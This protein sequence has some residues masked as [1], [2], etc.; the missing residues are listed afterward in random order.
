MRFLTPVPLLFTL[1]CPTPAEPPPAPE[2]PRA[3]LELYMHPDGKT[4]CV[5]SAD[6]EWQAVPSCCPDGFSLAG[7]SAPAVSLYLTEEEREIR[8]IYRHVVCLEDRR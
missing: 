8:R 6:G 2:A 4:N 1:G 7:F 3:T 5:E